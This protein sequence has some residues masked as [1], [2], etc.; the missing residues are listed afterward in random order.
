MT[1]GPRL[2]VVVLWGGEPSVKARSSFMS[3]TLQFP[4]RLRVWQLFF[5]LPLGF[6]KTSC[7]LRAVRHF[8]LAFLQRLRLSERSLAIIRF[9]FMREEGSLRRRGFFDSWRTPDML[10][11]LAP[12]V[13]WLD[14]NFPSWPFGLLRLTLGT[15]PDGLNMRSKVIMNAKRGHLKFKDL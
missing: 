4:E 11:W 5:F 10:A 6:I 13:K 3:G 14:I 15:W 9:V 7:Q 12:L 2:G 8:C 1:A